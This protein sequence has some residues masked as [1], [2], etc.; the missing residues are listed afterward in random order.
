MTLPGGRRLFI[1][2]TTV[3]LFSFFLFAS[4]ITS[5]AA[6]PNGISKTKLVFESGG[7]RI[8]MERFQSNRVP[9]LRAVI[10]LHGAGGTILDGPEMRR[11]AESLATSGHPTYL[12]Y[13]F[14]RTGTIVGL[15]AGMQKN[16]DTWLA[17]VRDAIVA[18]QK[19]CGNVESVGIYGYSLGGFLALAVASDNSRVGAVLDHAGGIWNGKTERIRNMPPVLVMHGERDERVPFAK[20]AKPLVALLRNR[21]VKVETRYFTDEGHG[22]SAA[23]RKTVRE[24]AVKFFGRQLQR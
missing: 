8:S 20:Y 14:D 5:R 21:G 17:T 13:Y 18:V 19:D 23:A 9:R 10:V 2:T 16:F 24:D 4:G 11:V 22:F 1:A 15:D 3:V 12:V 7:R 6:M